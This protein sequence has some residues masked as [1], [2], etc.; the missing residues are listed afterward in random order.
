MTDALGTAQTCHHG[1]TS[2]ECGLCSGERT[3][4][5]AAA[6]DMP[7]IYFMR[8]ESGW[9]WAAW[10][11]AIHLVH[12]AHDRAECGRLV[13]RAVRTQVSTGIEAGA[14]ADCWR[15]VMGTRQRRAG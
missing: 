5:R 6:A 7:V 4:A 14:C 10:H 1:S 2:P 8:R 13:P 9:A 12:P 11:G 15:R 3:R